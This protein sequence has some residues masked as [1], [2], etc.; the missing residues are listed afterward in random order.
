MSTP[1]VACRRYCFEAKTLRSADRNLSLPRAQDLEQGF[2]ATNYFSADGWRGQLS[3]PGCGMPAMLLRSPRV[4]R[5]RQW[6]RIG[7]MKDTHRRARCHWRASRLYMNQRLQS[8]FRSNIVNHAAW[9]TH[10][11]RNW[12]RH[13]PLCRERILQV[14]ADLRIVG[15][16]GQRKRRR[17]GGRVAGSRGDLLVRQQSE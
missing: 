12:H 17:S 6:L 16:F 9:V 4:F 1:R 2:C 14:N 7:R 15:L 13:R 5:V 3:R 11:L 8:G 10:S